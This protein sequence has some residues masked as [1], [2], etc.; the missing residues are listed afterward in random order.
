MARSTTLFGR[1]QRPGRRGRRGLAAVLMLACA[2]LLLT[3]CSTVTPPGTSGLAPGPTGVS[4]RSPLAGA[5]TA[6]PALGV[7]RPRRASAVG[8]LVASRS[9][10]LPLG[11]DALDD[12]SPDGP[13]DIWEADPEDIRTEH[14][15]Q[16]AEMARYGE[17]AALAQGRYERALFAGHSVTDRI[18]YLEDRNAALRAEQ[19]AHATA[20]VL[21]ALYRSQTGERL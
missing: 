8:P 6:G 2:G 18:G 17:S 1:S 15:T 21:G 14:A 16:L 5:V 9:G 12:A 11:G 19:E 20:V 10:G 7:S 4:T 3:G 13:R